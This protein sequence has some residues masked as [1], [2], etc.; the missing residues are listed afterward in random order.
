VVA[1]A[2]G[3][4]WVGL[5]RLLLNRGCASGAEW[6]SVEKSDTASCPGSVVLAAAHICSELMQIPVSIH[7]CTMLCRHAIAAGMAPWDAFSVQ[8]CLWLHSKRH[9]N[10][11]PGWE[12]NF[13]LKGRRLV[14]MNYCAP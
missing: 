7:C 13:R 3:L 6:V 12:L 4:E 2:P 10:L 9:S 1:G 5:P 8:Q 14:P 11:T